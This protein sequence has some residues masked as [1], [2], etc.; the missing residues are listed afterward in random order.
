MGLISGIFNSA[1][2]VKYTT[3]RDTIVGLRV[4]SDEMSADEY[5]KKANEK[6]YGK[7]DPIIQLYNIFTI[8][9]NNNNRYERLNC[10]DQESI[11]DTMW[12]KADDDN[13]GYVSKDE[14]TD[15]YGSLVTANA[16]LIT[17]KNV[18]LAAIAVS[19]I[20]SNNDKY[21]DEQKLEIAN[22]LEADKELD[23]DN[24]GLL[25][26]DEFEGASINY[27]LTPNNKPQK[28]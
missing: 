7:R 15:L 2:K 26:K 22:F 16:P 25:S 10:Y 8:I 11:Y 24:D 3:P 17:A 13:D 21:T 6:L 4:V 18:A 9:K 28:S 23:I 27:I 5:L 12:A 20:I 19:P 14:L 1:P